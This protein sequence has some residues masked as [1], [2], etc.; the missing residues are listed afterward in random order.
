MHNNVNGLDLESL[1][2]EREPFCDAEDNNAWLVLDIDGL[3]LHGCSMLH[4]HC[5]QITQTAGHMW[6]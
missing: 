5:G 6:T 4:G 2:W 3:Q 1:T